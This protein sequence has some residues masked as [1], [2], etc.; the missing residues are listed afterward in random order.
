MNQASY[1]KLKSFLN[2]PKQICIVSHWNPDGDAVGSSLGLSLI[3]KKL[4]HKVV[5]VL[6][7]ETPKFLKWLPEAED[8]VY[9]DYDNERAMYV[10]HHSDIVFTLDFNAFHRVGER[11]QGILVKLNCP[12]VLIDHHQSPDGYAEYC[13]SDT[14]IP[15]TCQMIYHFAEQM[16]WEKHIDHRIAS[17]LYTGIVTD[18]GSFKFS[19]TTPETHVVASKLLSKGINGGEIQTRLFDQ[20]SYKK[21]QLLGRALQ[22]MV[23]LPEVEASYIT[24][25]EQDLNEFQYQKGDTEGIVNYGLAVENINV[26]ALFIERKEENMIK[27]S[28]RSVGSFDVN[29]FSRQFFEGGGHI[30]AAGGKSFLTM[31]E[32]VE[33]F[34]KAMKE[35]RQASTN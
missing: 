11:M 24:L 32:T 34:K 23:L 30:N 15:S 35:Y 28:F 25:S 9:F 19:S 2:Q 27:A 29:Q 14:T 4:G 31:E 13:Y 7:N 18:T 26:T 33:K 10:L 20:H 12:F 3:L 21:L 22:N 5:V 8:I 1:I 6:P 17:C 16:G